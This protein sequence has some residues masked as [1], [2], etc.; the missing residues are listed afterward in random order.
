MVSLVPDS[1]FKEEQDLGHTGCIVI[2]MTTLYWRG[3]A[4]NDAA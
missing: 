2:S 4:L 3:N 1:T